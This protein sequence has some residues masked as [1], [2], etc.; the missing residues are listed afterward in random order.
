MPVEF[1]SQERRQRLG[2]F[3]DDP[4]PEQLAAYFHLDDADRV[5]VNRRSRARARL[6]FAVQLGTVRFLGTF[7]PDPTDGPRVV[8]DYLAV[9]LDISNP[10]VLKGYGEGDTRPGPAAE[11]C[12]GYGYRDFTDE[13]GHTTLRQW[14]ESR[15]WTMGERQWVLFDLTVAWLHEH[16]VLLP[17]LEDAPRG[18]GGPKGRRAC[19]DR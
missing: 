10:S 19:R 5:L 13:P 11:I 14:L 3:S 4:T 18:R 16:K 15:A 2:R 6:G 8:V 9:Q 17:G 1:L 12:Y 7:L